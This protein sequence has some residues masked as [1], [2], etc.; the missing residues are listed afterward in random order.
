MRQTLQATTVIVEGEGALTDLSH[1]VGALG[2]HDTTGTD[3]LREAGEGPITCTAEVEGP[4]GVMAGVSNTRWWREKG[5][6]RRC[7]DKGQKEGQ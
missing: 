1:T 4:S 2:Q 3:E 5:E 6:G 7:Y